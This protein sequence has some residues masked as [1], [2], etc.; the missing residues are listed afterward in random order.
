MDTDQVINDILVQ[1]T[2]NNIV[3][4]SMETSYNHWFL[5][6]LKYLYYVSPFSLL[7]HS[8]EHDLAIQISKNVWASS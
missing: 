4:N 1:D 8:K 7:T 3:K 5:N 2:I 6:T